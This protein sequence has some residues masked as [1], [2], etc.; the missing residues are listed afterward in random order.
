MTFNMYIERELIIN[1]KAN[2]NNRRYPI[3]ILELIR[4]QIN[5]SDKWN[6][7][8]ILGLPTSEV[9]TLGQVAFIYTNA[10]VEDESLYCDIEIIDTKRG[11]ELKQILSYESDGHKRIVFRP[12]GMGTFRGEVPEEVHN[13]LNVPNVI[14]DDYQLLTISAIPAN[15]DAVNL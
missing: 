7:T 15:E 3:N 9:I 13:L 8:G 2:K 12:S 14:A 5:R 11:D 1:T 4:D 6:N 10:I